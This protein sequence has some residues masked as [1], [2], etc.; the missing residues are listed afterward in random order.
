MKKIIFLFTLILLMTGCQ[1]NG[2]SKDTKNKNLNSLPGADLQQPVSFNL[3]IEKKDADLPKDQ[4][5]FRLAQNSMDIMPLGYFEDQQTKKEGIAYLKKET[6]KYEFYLFADGKV[7]KTLVTITKTCDYTSFL[8]GIISPDG[9]KIAFYSEVCE[10]IAA[11]G[12]HASLVFAYQRLDNPLENFSIASGVDGHFGLGDNY[13]FSPDSLKIL[14][15]TTGGDE[16]GMGV[17]IA[18]YDLNSKINTN[19]FSY[20]NWCDLDTGD[21]GGDYYDQLIALGYGIQDNQASP[22][23]LIGKAGQTQIYKDKILFA[24][25]SKEAGAID[26]P[27]QTR[28]S[29]DG[30][31]LVYFKDNSLFRLPISAKDFSGAKPEVVLALD[32]AIKRLAFSEQKVLYVDEENTGQCLIQSLY[33]YD[34][35]NKEFIDKQ[36]FCNE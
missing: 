28:I 21:C 35:I 2:F 13:F 20:S 29:K 18:E 27:G 9:K 4:E 31:S 17:K 23:Y 10:K 26:L 3:N 12:S 15:T 24:S 7:T 19:L 11:G 1:L 36:Q 6:D 5:K 32:H 33:S 22:Y 25:A 8:S 14:F 34:G 30:Q 16:N